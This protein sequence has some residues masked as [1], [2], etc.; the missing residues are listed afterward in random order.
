MKKILV[1]GMLTLLLFPGGLAGKGCGA[2]F[3]QTEYQVED[4][5]L[6]QGADER[7]VVSLDFKDAN[8]KDVLKVFSQQS[9]MN[10]VSSKN[11]EDK[12]V[13]LYMRDVHVE[14]A[15]RTLL[16]A[17]N[18][19]LVQSPGS[20][21]IIVKEKPT[22]PI[23]TLT[24]VYRIRYFHSRAIPGQK[25]TA[26]Q[27]DSMVQSAWIEIIRPLLSQF[28]NVV[29][30]ANLIIVTDVPDRFKLVDQVISE[31]DKPIAEVMLEVEMIETTA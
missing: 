26:K 23:E 2:V 1:G 27:G 13:T 17:N 21:I 3:A 15:L 6:R 29:A 9:G 16:D 14:D 5:D 20:N 30:F 10:F 12:P 31:I 11:V 19:A 24:R 8:L 4:D 22:P 7:G 18:L 25:H 28:G